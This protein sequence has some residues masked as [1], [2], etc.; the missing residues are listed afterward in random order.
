MVG[1]WLGLG[2]ILMGALPSQGSGGCSYPLD[3]RNVV[4]GTEVVL[5]KGLWPAVPS[6]SHLWA[7]R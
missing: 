7:C 5:L 2:L 1:L 6:V 3:V 4:L